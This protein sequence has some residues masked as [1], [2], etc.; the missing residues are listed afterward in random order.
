VLSLTLVLIVTG[1]L[2]ST[3][4]ADLMQVLF[5]TMSAFGTVGLSM[6]ITPYLTAIGKILIALTMLAGR[7]GP[8]TLAVAFIIHQVNSAVHYP[9]ERVI[10]G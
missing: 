8:F 6:G 2:L 7:V 1:V 3:E 10:V 5:E 4:D 9:E